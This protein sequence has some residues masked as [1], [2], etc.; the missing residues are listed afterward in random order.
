M[1]RSA[2][3]LNMVL[4]QRA[5]V[6]EE[7]QRIVAGLERQRLALHGRVGAIN[8]S[9]QAIRQELREALTPNAGAGVAAFGDIRM[10]AG[11]TLHAQI[12]LQTLAIELAG[13][14]NRL[15]RARDELRAAAASRKAVQLL[16]DRWSAEAKRAD[17]RRE[18]VA[19][20]EISMSRHARTD[21][22]SLET[23]P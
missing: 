5:R 10:Q 12:H 11:A 4:A 21:V 17:D 15:D 23:F 8:G 19:I 7:K 14:N 1:A 16:L 6:E 20:D 13:M 2:K 3:Q 9:L 22:D 18:A